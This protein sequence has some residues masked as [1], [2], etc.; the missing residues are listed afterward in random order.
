M[1]FKYYV[2]L[3]VCLL[4]IPLNAKA[5]ELYTTITGNN[6]IKAGSE[7]KYTII[8]DTSLTEYGAEIE[9][10]REILNFVDAEEEKIDTENKA[11]SVEKNNPIKINI[12]SEEPT[13]IVYTLIFNVKNDIELKDT[14]LKIKTI[15]AK[16]MIDKKNIEL[17]ASE[18]S[19]E[20]KVNSN[21]QLNVDE[22]IV[23]NDK[24]IDDI[25]KSVL[26]IKDFFN[27]YKDIIM[28]SSLALNFILIIV[29]IISIKRKKM[30]YDF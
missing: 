12:T 21:E 10:D 30:D 18:I 14:E 6:N 22:E 20:I 19:F 24:K 17:S 13:I 3:I 25:K 1:K 5:E 29:L 11:F 4:F 28:Y 26:K 27:D 15:N 7:V 8:L 16:T 9:Y 23:D 2:L